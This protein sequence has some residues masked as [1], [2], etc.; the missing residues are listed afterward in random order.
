MNERRGIDRSF[1]GKIRSLIEPHD[2][3]ESSPA[4]MSYKRPKSRQAEKLIVENNAAAIVCAS[5]SLL[6]LLLRL[7]CLAQSLHDVNIWA[8]EHLQQRCMLSLQATDISL[9]FFS[10]DLLYLSQLRWHRLLERSSSWCLPPLN[11]NNLIYL[12]FFFIFVHYYFSSFGDRFHLPWGWAAELFV[13][14]LN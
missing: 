2:F 8:L 7:L 10:N 12:S 4:Y 3:V 1:L 6:L 14:T 9:C 11:S 13:H 5:F